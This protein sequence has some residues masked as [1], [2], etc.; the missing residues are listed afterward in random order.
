MKIMKLLPGIVLP[1]IVALLLN[2]FGG[3]LGRKFLEFNMLLYGTTQRPRYN[4][5]SRAQCITISRHRVGKALF[6]TKH[7]YDRT[8]PPTCS[9]CNVVLTI[10]HI[11]SEYPESRIDV[12]LE[13][14]LDCASDGYLSEIQMS[15]LRHHISDA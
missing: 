12:P 14:I 10:P 8:D 9:F 7:Y 1:V 13:K 5:F 15:L 3:S 11:L 6:N 2:V 4:N